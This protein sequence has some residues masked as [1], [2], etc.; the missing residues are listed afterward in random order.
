[1]AYKTIDEFIKRLEEEGEL[2]RVKESVSPFLEIAEINDRLVKNNG[3]AVLFENTGTEFPVLVNMMGSEKRIAAALNAGRLDEVGDRIKSLFDMLSSPKESLLDKLRMLPQLR[4]IASW[5]PVKV[6]GKGL[7]QKEEIKDA[8][9]GKLPVL[10]TWPHDGGP[11][12]TLPVVHTISPVSK[13]PN[14]GMY[15]MQIFDK[16][17][18]GMHWHIHKD[19][20]SQYREYKERGERMPVTVTI[21]GDPAY[22]YAATAPLPEN[23]DEYML[24]GFLRRKKVRLVKCLTN[25]LYVPEDVDFV[26]EGYVD[27]AEELKVEGPFGDHTGYYSLEDKYPVFHVT[28]ITHRPGAV[29]SATV[30]GI[31]PQEDAWIGLA[32]ERIFLNPIKMTMIP[33]I[34]D[35]HMPP[36][37]VFHNIV[38]TSIKTSYPGQAVKVMSALWG[39]GQMMFNKFLILLNDNIKLTDYKAVLAEISRNTDPVKDVIF[40][41]GPMDVLDHASEKFAYGGKMGINATNPV[42]SSA[43]NP[44]VDSAACRNIDGVLEVNDGLTK[45][46]I[47]VL[48]LKV[49]KS[50]GKTTRRIAR[51]IVEQKL[52]TGVKFVVF[53]EEKSCINDLP[54]IV[55]RAANNTDPA[56]DCFYIR[57]ENNE[58]YPVL[59]FDAT[60]KTAAADGFDRPWPN[61]VTM[62]EKTIQLV[63]N[64]WD[65][66]GLGKFTESPSVKYR[67]QLYNGG[68]VAEE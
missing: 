17:T 4:E 40:H 36:E 21:G 32:T 66:Y 30:V 55:W 60:R 5:A 11:F 9:L 29:Y 68:A 7:C 56:R 26:I 15:R 22:I 59:F 19:G 46:G 33:E 41:R 20:A 63:D 16:N 31:P 1:M 3:K 18:T 42:T 47:A 13:T 23:I 25:D 27:P 45:E 38:L 14:T 61:I 51:Q 65:S 35:M 62:D 54:D 37:G 48:I 12:I 43:D 34:S 67:K 2:I 50:D 24:A 57:N 58:E 10:T 28:K 53:A 8:D 44:A 6:K 64:K 52:I 49:K 39:A